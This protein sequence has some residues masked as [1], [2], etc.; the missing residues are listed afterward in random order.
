MPHKHVLLVIA[1]VAASMR[2][3]PRSVLDYHFVITDLLHFSSCLTIQFLLMTM[4]MSMN[5]LMKRKG[6]IEA[7]RQVFP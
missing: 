6:R 4:D 5:I 7:G 3:G 2:K 1:K